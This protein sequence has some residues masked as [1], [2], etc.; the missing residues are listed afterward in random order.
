MDTGPSSFAIDGVDN[1]KMMRLVIPYSEWPASEP[2]LEAKF[3]EMDNFA[4]PILA[5]DSGHTWNGW[6]CPRFPLESV[7]QIMNSCN[8][9]CD[10]GIKFASR[11]NQRPQV[12]IRFAYGVPLDADD[13]P[14]ECGG[15]WCCTENGWELLFALGSGYWT[16]SWAETE[17][18]REDRVAK[19][20]EA[21]LEA[22]CQA[23]QDSLRDANT[24]NWGFDREWHEFYNAGV[25]AV[26]W[27][28]DHNLKPIR[29][30]D[31]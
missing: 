6:A 10:L 28:A 16:W 17:S 20:F 14:L 23:V 9:A 22:F 21:G 19:A 12:T 8:A 24:D 1:T 29:T 2:Q 7:L 13:E 15:K 26:N 11:E 27:F 3:V 4:R 5:Y 25:E 18:E 31:D 30:S